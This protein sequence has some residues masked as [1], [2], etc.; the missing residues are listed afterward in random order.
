MSRED[1]V[2]RLVDAARE[3]EF[4]LSE[5]FECRGDLIKAG[6]NMDG[7]EGIRDRLRAALAAMDAPKGGG[8]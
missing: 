6:F 8:E 3:A 5:W 1:D 2:A 7:T 4:D